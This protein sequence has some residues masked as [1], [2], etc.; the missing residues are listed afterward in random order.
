MSAQI[1]SARG[2]SGGRRGIA[3]RLGKGPIIGVALVT[4]LV[5]AL[6]GGHA[7]TQLRPASHD[8]N[9]TNPPA[10]GS[11][12]SAAQ[13]YDELMAQREDSIHTIAAGVTGCN[14][15]MLCLS[16]YAPNSAATGSA[17]E[18]GCGDEMICP[19]MSGQR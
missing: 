12:V 13:Y 19:W 17:A 3:G 10:P 16:M 14:D 2:I 5:V 4:L 7:L 6:L 9:G 11:S 15:E 8:A 18:A 1:I